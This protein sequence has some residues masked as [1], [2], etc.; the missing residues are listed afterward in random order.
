MT[1]FVLLQG[2]DNHP[3]VSGSGGSTGDLWKSSN[4]ALHREPAET[5]RSGRET[6]GVLPGERQPV[7]VQPLPGTWSLFALKYFTRWT[8]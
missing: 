6:G 2:G 1:S 4:P 3:E 5:H 8:L 7:A